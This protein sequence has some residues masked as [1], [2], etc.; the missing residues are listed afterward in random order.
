MGS[1]GL[2]PTRESLHELAR[3]NAAEIGKG[4]TEMAWALFRPL[5]EVVAQV[6]SR[7]GWDEVERLRDAGRPMAVAPHWAATT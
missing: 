5:D 6:K 4:A 2:C 7:T 1:S 3:R